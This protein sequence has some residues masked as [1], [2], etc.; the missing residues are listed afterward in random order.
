MSYNAGAVL[1]AA[2]LGARA[3]WWGVL[4]AVSVTGWIAFAALDWFRRRQRGG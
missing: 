2:V 4:G 3:L 1:A